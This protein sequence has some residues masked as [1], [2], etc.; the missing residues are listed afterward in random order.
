MRYHQTGTIKC[1]YLIVWLGADSLLCHEYKADNGYFY[2]N[3]LAAA[4]S[5]IG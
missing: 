2:S 3:Y 5:V 1:S 4:H